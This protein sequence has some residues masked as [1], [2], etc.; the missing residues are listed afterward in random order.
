MI[1]STYC[2]FWKDEVRQSA[3]F[4]EIWVPVLLCKMPL[5]LSS[6]DLVYYMNF[7]QDYTCLS[8]ADSKGI[9]IWSLSTHKLCYVADI[10]A[11]R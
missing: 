3:S 1:Q 10:G 11:V 9:K 6:G 7:N 4:E 5:K 2:A 8:I